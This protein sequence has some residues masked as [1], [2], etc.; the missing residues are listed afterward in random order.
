M[1]S[2]LKGMSIGWILIVLLSTFGLS[3]NEVAKLLKSLRIFCVSL[4]EAEMT[5]IFYYKSHL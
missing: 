4:V 2:Y 5:A 1:H 3:V